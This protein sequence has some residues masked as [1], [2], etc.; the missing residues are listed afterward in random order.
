MLTTR[1]RTVIKSRVARTIMFLSHI[2]RTR[3]RS[4]HLRRFSSEPMS[5]IVSQLFNLKVEPGFSLQ[6]A[7]FTRLRMIARLGG[8]NEQYYGFDKGPSDRLCWIIQWPKHVNPANFNVDGFRESVNALDVNKAPQSWLVPFDSADLPRPGLTA[9]LTEFACVHV[10]TST[11][12]KE[13]AKSLH[14]TFADC[15]DAPDGGFVGGYRGTALNDDKMHWY[16]LGWV[17]REHHTKYAQSE[18]FAVELDKL[19]P[20]WMMELD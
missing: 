19:K 3:P 10:S 15:Y 12:S 5:A 8:A 4:I 13:D 7:A 2:S 20:I 1:F 6:S 11:P 9:P 16:Y 14:Q 18:L 17:D